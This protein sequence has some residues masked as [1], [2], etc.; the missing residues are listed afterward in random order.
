M[1]L[2]PTSLLIELI[3]NI[4]IGVLFGRLIENFIIIGIIAIIAI[5][6]VSI[7]YQEY[8]NPV[9]LTTSSGSARFLNYIDEI[10]NLLVWFVGLI[11][12]L[13]FSAIGT[14]IGI[15][16]GKIIRRFQNSDYDY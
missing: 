11:P 8:T 9:I 7:I 5:I 3:V 6:T 15:T 1:D 12:S 13:L 16:I 4:P 14:G 10:E 2:D